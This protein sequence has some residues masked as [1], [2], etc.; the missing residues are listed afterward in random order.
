MDLEVKQFMTG[1]PV[2]I[3]P[4]ASAL[5]AL[6]LMIDAAIRH[7]PV[8]DRSDRLRGVISFDDL[9]AALPIP[10]SLKVPL[11][12]EARQRVLD[13]SVGDVM[14]YSPV[15]VR[16]DAG[17]DEAVEK[18]LEGHFGCL[19][20][21]DENGRLDGILTET[22][23]LDALATML[24]TMRGREPGRAPDDLVARLEKERAHLV[25]RLHDY[26]HL[27]QD[28]TGVRH[29]TPMDR[30]E[31]G[32]TAEQSALTEQLAAMA[33]RRLR[34]IEKA[35]ERAEQGKLDRCERCGQR[36]PEPRLRALPGT[37]L[38]IRCGRAAEQPE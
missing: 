27:E 31:Q 22:D 14:T 10:I 9:R 25:E 15:T 3:E 16:S 17:L 34:S 30:A 8:V 2:F 37:T 20:V 38:C 1:S 13:Q 24:W 12:A 7:L 6:D 33:S 19:P 23:L 21:L 11:S 32:E 29:E 26:E 35:L 5:A 36:I 28:L 4:E 18:M